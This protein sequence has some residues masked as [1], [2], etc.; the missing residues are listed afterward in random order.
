MLPTSALWKQW[1]PLEKATY[2]AQVLA[3]LSLLPTVVFAWLG[4]REARLARE[5][6]ARYFSAEK[7]PQVNI[8]RVYN[9]AGY[10]IV[11][12]R[13]TGDSTARAIQLRPSVM[14]IDG[15]TA[16][17]FQDVPPPTTVL[18]NET[19]LM[20][21]MSITSL[22]ESVGF[23][24]ASYRPF[25]SAASQERTPVLH[26]LVSYTDAASNPYSFAIPFHVLK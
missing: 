7:A 15:S 3:S 10:V 14:R 5:D 25:T 11:E 17:G 16:L 18:K 26:L 24:P 2:V 4:W 23:Q 1:T 9:N 22:T 19:S 12:V 13:N 20:R 21:L 8:P 6:Q